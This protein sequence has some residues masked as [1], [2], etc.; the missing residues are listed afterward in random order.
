MPSSNEKKF[1]LRSGIPLE[2]SVAKKVMKYNPVELGD[3]EYLRE[4]KIFSTD[5][6]FS[7]IFKIKE[8]INLWVNFV[9]ECKYKEKNHEWF[10]F[11]FPSK[12]E[13]DP[14][15][16]EDFFYSKYDARN[17]VHDS[18]FKPIM[19]MKGFRK[20]NES[21][22][23]LGNLR[24]EIFSLTPVH[25]GVDIFRHGYNEKVIQK[26]VSQAIFGAMTA[27]SRM[28]LCLI[29]NIEELIGDPKEP[30][31]SNIVALM[32]IPII[33][34]TA[35][36]YVLD[37]NIDIDDLI[38]SDNVKEHFMSVPGVILIKSDYEIFKDYEKTLSK[39]NSVEFSV[40]LKNWMNSDVFDELKADWL[41]FSLTDTIT[42]FV[43]II[44][45]HSFDEG[46]QQIFER[47]AIICRNLGNNY[48]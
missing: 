11:Q 3:L 21:P 40:E 4:G 8:G 48:I 31:L 6:Y 5:L 1:I 12:D 20:E 43:P 42:E 17:N 9:I 44:N 19:R 2:V 7:R 26:A 32:S 36:L 27:Q 29:E 37:K 46:F 10:F 16:S 15:L 25:K 39:N 23:A 14:F 38:H 35:K 34:T 22:D 41:K 47:I 33:I 30:Y 24:S 28:Y 13:E 45:Y 18:F